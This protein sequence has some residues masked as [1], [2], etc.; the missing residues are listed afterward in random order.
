MKNQDTVA[1]WCFPSLCL[2]VYEQFRV[3]P[4]NSTS[5]QKAAENRGETMHRRSKFYSCRTELQVWVSQCYI[6]FTCVAQWHDKLSPNTGGLFK[7]IPNWQEDP[8]PSQ[9]SHYAASK[10]NMTKRFYYYNCQTLWH[11]TRIVYYRAVYFSN[12]PFGAGLPLI[13]VRHHLFSLFTWKLAD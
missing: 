12:V 7:P 6:S 13:T 11:P 10:W 4:E 9:D 8:V 3:N 5:T 2:Q 1:G